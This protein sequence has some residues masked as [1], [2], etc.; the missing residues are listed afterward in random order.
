MHDAAGSAA[1]PAV[2][3]KNCLRWGS[4][5]PVPPLPADICSAKGHVRF[6][7]ESDHKSRHVA[8]GHVRYTPESGHPQCKMKGPLRAN[9][10]LMQCSKPLSYSITSSA[11]P[12]SVFGTLRPSALAVLRLITNS[13]FVAARTGRCGAA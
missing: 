11:R 1:T 4:F 13:Y 6:T 12:I 10:G 9:S 8:N 3:Y 5:I 2:R 7:P